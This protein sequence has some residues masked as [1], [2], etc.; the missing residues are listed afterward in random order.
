MGQAPVAWISPLGFSC[1]QPY[2]KA[3][4]VRMASKRQSAGQHRGVQPGL[5]GLGRM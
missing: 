2:R 5:E 3:E 4:T 1:S